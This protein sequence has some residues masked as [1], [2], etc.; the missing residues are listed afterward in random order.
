[1]LLF[2]V[3]LYAEVGT[4]IDKGTK[5]SPTLINRLKQWRTY[6]ENVKNVC[7]SLQ[8]YPAYKGINS[9]IYM[10]VKE[11]N[12]KQHMHIC[13]SSCGEKERGRFSSDNMDAGSWWKQNKTKYKQWRIYVRKKVVR[14]DR[15]NKHN[16]EQVT[17]QRPDLLTANQ[18]NTKL[19]E[20]EGSYPGDKVRGFGMK[21]KIRVYFGS[22]WVGTGLSRNCLLFWKIV[23]Q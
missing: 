6:F 14:E 18:E 9:S 11:Y 2:L 16:T 4:D 20:E 21:E 7:N 19:E 10:C 3:I 17:Y 15:E 23:P 12:F 1:M 22:G 13:Y 8:L 5:Y